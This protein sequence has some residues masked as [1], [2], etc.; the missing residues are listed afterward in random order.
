MIGS[1]ARQTMIGSRDKLSQRAPTDPLRCVHNGRRGRYPN[2]TGQNR[3]CRIVSK[4]FLRLSSVG[5][6]SLTRCKPLLQSPGLEPL[7]PLPPPLRL[8]PCRLVLCRHSLGNVAPRQRQKRLSQPSSE[9]DPEGGPLRHEECP[10]VE[11][12][13]KMR[14]VSCRR[15]DA[16]CW[17]REA[18]K[19]LPWCSMT[20]SPSAPFPCPSTRCR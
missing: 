20:R 11:F 10:S 5:V 1:S 16:S 6:T 8:T 3:K 7:V 2:Q 17:T 13:R 12:K 15:R 9:L 19:E 18:Q 4:S 14:P